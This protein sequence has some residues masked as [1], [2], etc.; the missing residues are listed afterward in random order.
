MYSRGEY[1][2]MVCGPNLRNRRPSFM[3]VVIQRSASCG[4]LL[5]T[6][7]PEEIAYSIS[8][9]L[10][11]R[12]E[13]RFRTN[14]AQASAPVASFRGMLAADA[15]KFAAFRSFMRLGNLSSASNLSA[16][17]SRALPS[18]DPSSSLSRPSSIAVSQRSSSGS[19]RSIRNA[20][21][22]VFS[23]VDFRPH[24]LDGTKVDFEGLRPI[25][26]LCSEPERLLSP[27]ISLCRQDCI[28]SGFASS[29]M[30]HLAAASTAL[31]PT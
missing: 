24:L 16:S 29:L 1:Q 6:S 14:A 17:R 28:T 8:C 31:Q 11:M 25:D 21:F 13:D 4:V 26:V 20:T 30:I 22:C 2:V 12:Q 5:L 9:V 23:S 19:I 15:R 27:V 7:E 10:S 3:R 18:S